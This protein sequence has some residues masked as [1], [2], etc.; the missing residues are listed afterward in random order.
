MEGVREEQRQR[1]IQKQNRESMRK[2]NG[3]RLFTIL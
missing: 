1:Q 3:K 2:R